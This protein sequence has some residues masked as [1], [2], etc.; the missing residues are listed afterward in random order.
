MKAA[1]D[2]QMREAAAAKGILDRLRQASPDE[3]EAFR[4]WYQGE[5]PIAPASRPTGKGSTHDDILDD[6]GDTPAPAL[7]PAAA[8]RIDKLERGLMQMMEVMQGQLDERRAIDT[9]SEIEAAMAQFTVFDG[10][11]PTFRRLAKS[12][13]LERVLQGKGQTDVLSATHEWAKH[14]QSMQQE[15]AANATRPMGSG[16]PALRPGQQKVRSGKDL[17]EGLV[18]EDVSLRFNFGR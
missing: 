12:H 10:M 6:E 17:L 3:R 15:A 1:S 8:S 14:A 13:I 4:R 5:A 16:I 7:H 9:S 2:L 11:T 18:D